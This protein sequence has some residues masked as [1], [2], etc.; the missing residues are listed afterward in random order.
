MT[1]DIFSSLFPSLVLSFS[2]T[3]GGA[4]RVDGPTQ[5]YDERLEEPAVK[6]QRT[7]G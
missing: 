1:I 3:G 7:E 6:K 4:G 5:P 2:S